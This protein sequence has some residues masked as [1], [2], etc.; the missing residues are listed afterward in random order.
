M[1]ICSLISALFFSSIKYFA[2]Y[3][4]QLTWNYFIVVIELIFSGL[5]D[6]LGLLQKRLAVDHL[7]PSFQQIRDFT[8][9]DR[10]K[11]TLYLVEEGFM[12]CYNFNSLKFNQQDAVL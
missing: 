9:R 11:V 1:G 10:E 2:F 7:C 4:L 5:Q 3:F 6:L 8:L 12:K